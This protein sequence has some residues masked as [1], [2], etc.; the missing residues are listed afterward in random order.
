MSSCPNSSPHF[1]TCEV[2]WGQIL[3]NDVFWSQDWG[4]WAKIVSVEHSWKDPISGKCFRK[5]IACKFNRITK[6]TVGSKG[7]IIVNLQGH[8]LKAI[9]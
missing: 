4:F 2:S 6:N 8:T 3:V 9:V 5:F 1:E 7:Q